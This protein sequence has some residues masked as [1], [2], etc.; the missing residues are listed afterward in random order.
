MKSSSRRNQ[1][2][3]RRI[4]AAL[5]SFGFAATAAAQIRVPTH[6]VGTNRPNANKAAGSAVAVHPPPLDTT[7][8]KPSTSQNPG[9]GITFTCDTNFAT[10]GPAGLCAALNSILPPLYSKTFSNANASVYILFDPSAGLANST[11]GFYNLVT[12]ATYYAALQ[13]ESTDAA[14]AFVP[15]QEPSIF[16]SDSVS[17]NGPLARVLGI[18]QSNDGSGTIG[19]IQ[20]IT[21]EGDACTTPGV[22]D[23]YDGVIRV[24]T[25]AMLAS[26]GDQGFTYRSLGGSTTGTTDNYDFFSIIE[27]EMDE[28][29]G[30]SSCVSYTDSGT[31]SNP[32][33][34]VAAVDLF[35][36]TANGARIIDGIGATAYFSPNGGLTDTDGNLY[37][38]EKSGEDWAD[39]SQ[40]CVFVQDAEGCPSGNDP[41]NSFDITTDGPGGTAGPE[42]AILN[43]V[44]YNLN[45]IQSSQTIT[46]PALPN[47]TYGVGPITLTATASSHLPV[48]YTVTGPA[49]LNGSTLTI[50]GAGMVTVTAS[51]PGNSSYAAATPVVRSFTVAK[52]G[53]SVTANNV[54]RAVGAANPSFTYTI[55][56]PVHGDTPAVVS[57][58]ATETT[59][60]TSSSL[61]GTYPITFSTESLTAANYT[62]SYVNGTLTITSATTGNFTITVIPPTETIRFGDIAGFILQLQSE[63]SF[64]ENVTLS[65]SGGPAGSYCADFPMTVKVD[66]TAYAVSGILFPENTKPGTYTITFKGVSGSLTNTATATFTVID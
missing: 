25:P 1:A 32:V 61:A 39:F 26:S 62:F 22:G 18:T 58:T 31:L 17:I 64:D 51:Q 28:I 37:S 10:Y 66:G 15:A 21:A 4:I 41:N 12:Y 49:T 8:S 35:R 65:C 40:S 63:N 6:G 47:V 20:Y 57:G 43:A 46:F 23:C 36:Y 24:V 9:P 48:S 59:A 7:T 5:L 19:P 11:T 33:N 52:A 38:P 42:V 2:K 60:A 27:H 13:T 3:S 30:T 56:G 55:T 34:C 44:G 14:K 53:L 50:T 16:G 29:L 45:P 54:S